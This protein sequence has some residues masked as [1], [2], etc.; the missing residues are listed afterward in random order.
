MSANHVLYW[1]EMDAI[2]DHLTPF[3]SLISGWRL[4]IVPLLNQS[5]KEY[6]PNDWNCRDCE[7][8]QSGKQRLI[9]L[10]KSSDKEPIYES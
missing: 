7:A 9:S 3:D 5:L 6:L 2:H 8:Q 10:T 1:L 4:R